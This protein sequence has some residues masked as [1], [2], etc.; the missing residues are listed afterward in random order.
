MDNAYSS[1][2]TAERLASSSTSIY[3]EYML[4]LD[5]SFFMIN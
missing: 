3:L 4:A 1:V 5:L 2:K